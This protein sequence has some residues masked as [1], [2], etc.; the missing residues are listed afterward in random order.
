MRYLLIHDILDIYWYYELFGHGF[1]EYQWKIFVLI[2][3]MCISLFIEFADFF[4]IRFKLFALLPRQFIAD[5]ESGNIGPS[6]RRSCYKGPTKSYVSATCIPWISTTS[7]WGALIG[8]AWRKKYI[9]I[10]KNTWTMWS[11][12]SNMTPWRGY[13]SHLFLVLKEEKDPCTTPF[14][15]GV[16]MV[17]NLIM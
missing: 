2:Q 3:Y 5:S 16:L 13:F 6:S 12:G 7:S 15:R 4:P 9:N 8:K 10:F 14:V 17:K 11:W 1:I